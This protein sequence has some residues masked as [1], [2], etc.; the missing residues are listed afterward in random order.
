VVDMYLQSFA[1]HR[2]SPYNPTP[3]AA[4]GVKFVPE[5]DPPRAELDFTTYDAAM[6]RALE[7]YHFTNF[8]VPVQGMGGGD[9]SGR[10]PEPKISEFGESTPQYQAMFSSYVKQLESHLREKGWLKMAYTYWYDEPQPE[11][12]AYVRAGMERLK[13]YAPGI[14]TMLT[15]E[16]HDELGNSID[17]W[18]PLTPE[19]RSDAAEKR[20]A[21]GERYWWYVCCGP[22]APFCTLFIDHPATELRT[23][24]WQS[25]QRNVVGILIWESV[26]W[27]SVGDPSQNPYHDPMGY[28]GGTKPE[29]KQYWGN[30]D[31]RFLY[32]PLAAATP[33]LSGSEPV[34]EPPVSSIRWEMLR[35]GIEDYEFL[36]LL[37]DLIG[38][39]RPS[40][41]PDQVKTY[42]ALLEVPETITRDITTFTTDPR[43]IY[44]RRAAIAEAIEQLTN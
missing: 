12:F 38:K 26:Y 3:L 24:L 10:G 30:G 16:P 23:W 37:R 4:I 1:D 9:W 8:V 17:I 7:K 21:Q 5:A 22:K 28:V 19:Y 6:S 32:P 31:G 35:E 34:I 15:K 2:I 29:Q 39:K 41:T 33:G 20:R 44:A 27:T 14:Q 18:C 43:P 40:L 11:V 36:W 13:K 42:E 25:W